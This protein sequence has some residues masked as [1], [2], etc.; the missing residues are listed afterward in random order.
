M[1]KGVSEV[2]M[3]AGVTGITVI[4]QQWA[5]IISKFA[6]DFVAGIIEG[7]ADRMK[8]ISLRLRDYRTKISR[9]FS[10]YSKLE[11]MFPEDDVS[12]LMKS[13]KQMMRAVAERERS[14]EYQLIINA[15]D[16]QYFRMY[17][18]QA[19]NALKLTLKDMT[20]DECDI[21]VS[22][23]SVLEREKEIS[24]MFIDGLVG[25]N[26]SRSLSFYLDYHKKYLN[27]INTLKIFNN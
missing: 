7:Y 21:L 17:Q 26:F 3:L 4:M 1:S 18:P 15:L 8:N 19:A 24:Q 14:L 27:E 9:L 23:Q 25:K 13:T 12:E 6:S 20:Q 10:V 5:A 2:L 16:L 22:S 11:L